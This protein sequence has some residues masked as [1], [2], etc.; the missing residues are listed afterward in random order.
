MPAPLRQVRAGSFQGT[1]GED[2]RGR[3]ARVK[4]KEVPAAS[5]RLS[6]DITK[7][8]WQ[9][10]SRGGVGVSLSGAKMLTFRYG[11]TTLRRRVRADRARGRLPGPHGPAVRDHAR[12]A[13][14]TPAVRVGGRAVRTAALAAGGPAERGPRGSGPGRGVARS[15]RPFSRAVGHRGRTAGRPAVPAAGAGVLLAALPGAGRPARRGRTAVRAAR[16]RRVDR[17]LAAVPPC[18]HRG[19]GGGRDGR[20]RRA[21]L[22]RTGDILGYGAYGAGQRRGRRLG[23][24]WRED[25]RSRG[26]AGYD[27]QVILAAARKGAG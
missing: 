6:E 9:A 17:A 15:R 19:V 8:V 16:L 11:R 7:P 1:P 10:E 26:P 4:S 27:R 18:D 25:N 3:K 12:S 2:A 20:T 21:H 5:P 24:G 22:L 23:D 13:A 14:R